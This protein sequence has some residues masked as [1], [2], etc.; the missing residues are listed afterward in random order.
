MAPVDHGDHL[1][2]ANLR[3]VADVA[4]SVVDESQPAGALSPAV[5]CGR[6]GG[7]VVRM[8]V[9]LGLEWLTAVSAA[10]ALSLLLGRRPRNVFERGGLP[11]CAVLLGTEYE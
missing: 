1:D 10:V 11:Y 8:P 3:S 5:P 4:G 9:G 2:G 6:A 7:S